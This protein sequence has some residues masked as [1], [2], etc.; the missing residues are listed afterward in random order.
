MIKPKIIAVDFDGTLV[1]NAYP[2]VGELKLN[3]KTVINKLKK[4]G[5]KIII[6][7]CRSG[8]FEGRVYE[9]L[10]EQGIEYDYIN[11]NLPTQIEYFKQDC[12]KI[13]ADIYIDDKNLGGTPDDWNV[14]YELVHKQI[15]YEQNSNN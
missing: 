8:I 5:F 2:N 15:E 4:E 9:F 7:T 12:R 11:S 6:N 1:E 3:A 10:E 14:I 13:S